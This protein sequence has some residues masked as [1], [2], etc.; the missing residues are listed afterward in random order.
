VIP[1]QP[2]ACDSSGNI[3]CQVS[4]ERLPISSQQWGVV[5]ISLGSLPSMNISAVVDIVVKGGFSSG[6]DSRGR[7]R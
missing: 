2:G 1:C 6:D 5:F 3:P 4:S 7:I